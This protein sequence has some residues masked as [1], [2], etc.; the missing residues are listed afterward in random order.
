MK[1]YFKL[2][3]KKT[4]FS[5]RT[6][7]SI[8]IILALLMIPYLEERAFPHPGLDGVDYFIKILHF[9]YIGFIGPVVAGLIYSTSIIKDKESGFI[10]KL[11]EVINIKTYFT[12][13][14]AVNTLITFV[15][16][17]VSHG[18]LILYLIISFGV[19]N[20]VVKDIGSGAF[21]GVYEVSKISYIIIMLLVISL[22][23]A[24]FSSFILGVITATQKKFIAYILPAC[25][26]IIT[27]I[28]FEVWSL[29]NIVDFNVTEL[30]NLTINQTTQVFGV[31]I[32]DL[33]LMLLGVSL[34]YKFGYKRN[35][36]LYQEI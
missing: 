21:T 34:L 2:E 13:K 1:T 7:I 27:G 5:L 33:I 28:F 19:S 6:I 26:V 10:N 15:V 9:S 4:I 29:N 8:L 20:T 18:I 22:S 23:S 14:L 31:I 35:L 36:A 25:Y 17:A 16:F 32:Y 30:F 3:L 24:A 12:V 11:L